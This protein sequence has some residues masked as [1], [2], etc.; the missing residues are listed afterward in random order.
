[1]EEREAVRQGPRTWVVVALTLTAVLAAA[2]LFVGGLV[3][4]VVISHDAASSAAPAPA[5]GAAS[6]AS[7]TTTAGAGDG[8][9]SG[10]G[11]LDPCLVGSW[12]TVEHSE[13]SD[14][15]QG[16]VTITGLQRT[17][18]ISEDGRERVTYDPTPAEITTDEGSGTIVF[19]GTAVYS[20]S[21]DGGRMSFELES[22]EGTVT[23]SVEGADPQTQDLTPGTGPV[24]YTCSG[25]RFVET[26]TGFRNVWER[27]S[28]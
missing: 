28:S 9:T 5:G 12:R 24:S 16:T 3:T 7:P 10:T 14:T 4:G 20:V 23:V 21:T 18:E 25:D 8:S 19:D 17:L 1:M 2:L 15:P 26:A 22:S 27:T 11:S 6:S 13:S